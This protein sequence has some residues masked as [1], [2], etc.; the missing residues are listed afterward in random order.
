MI[1]GRALV[2]GN[3]QTREVARNMFS[4]IREH[5]HTCRADPRHFH[6]VELFSN[7]ATASDDCGEISTNSAQGNICEENSHL[8]RRKGRVQDSSALARRVLN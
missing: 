2:L 6:H 5:E 4:S 3:R 8:E 7:S 1:S